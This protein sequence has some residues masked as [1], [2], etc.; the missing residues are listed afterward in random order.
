MFR[1]INKGCNVT[2]VIYT[3]IY[4]CGDVLGKSYLIEYKLIGMRQL[5]VEYI[6]IGRTGIN[7]YLRRIKQ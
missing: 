1:I 2:R 5:A 3:H 6:Q 7:V 4:D